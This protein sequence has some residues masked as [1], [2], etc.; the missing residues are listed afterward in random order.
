MKYCNLQKVSSIVLPLEEASGTVRGIATPRSEKYTGLLTCR[1]IEIISSSSWLKECN[2]SLPSV[3]LDSIFQKRTDL[4]EGN[5]T[6]EKVVGEIKWSSGIALETKLERRKG[7][8]LNSSREISEILEGSF[9]TC[10]ICNIMVREQAGKGVEKIIESRGNKI[11]L[12]VRFFIRNKLCI[13][14]SKDRSKE[15]LLDNRSK[16]TK[17]SSSGK[18]IPF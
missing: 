5:A 13:S 15:I 4:G 8:K 3:M 6:L 11:N 2:A 12:Y 14:N 16:K 17:L 1:E 10:I 18:V 7:S 9:E